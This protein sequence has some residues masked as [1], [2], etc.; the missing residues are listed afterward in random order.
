M[1]ASKATDPRTPSQTHRKGWSES[2]RP[3]ILLSLSERASPWRGSPSDGHR[4]NLSP[5]QPLGMPTLDPGATE[6]SPRSPLKR[7]LGSQMQE[8]VFQEK[9][10]KDRVKMIGVFPATKDTSLLKQK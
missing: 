10:K 1:I 6:R 4:Q 2:R 7:D 3:A 8:L 9:E 5:R